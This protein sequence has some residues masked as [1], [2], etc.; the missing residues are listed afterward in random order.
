MAIFSNE[1]TFHFCIS[2]LHNFAIFFYKF[3]QFALPNFEKPLIKIILLTVKRFFFEP[4]K[5]GNIA[6]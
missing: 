3:V 2:F 1:Y 4:K 5:C 6:L